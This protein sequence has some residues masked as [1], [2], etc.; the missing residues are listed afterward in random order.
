MPLKNWC[1][2]HARWSKSS[3]KNSIRF[4]GIFPNPDKKAR[5]TTNKKK[6]ESSENLCNILICTCMQK[7]IQHYKDELTQFFRKIYLLVYW[8]DCVWGSWRPNKDCNI[9][10]LPTLLALAAFLSRS[11]ELLN[12]GPGDLASAGTWLSFQHFLSN[13]SEL[14]VHIYNNL[15]SIYFLRASHLYSIQPVDSQG[16]PLISSSRCTCYLHMCI[17]HLT[18]RPGRR[19]ICNTCCIVN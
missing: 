17:S 8:K 1:S 16:Y 13:W 11:H 2:I 12:R 14:P 5:P 18:A 4:Y 10:T 15:T 6:K 7:H 3:V 9:L 19:S